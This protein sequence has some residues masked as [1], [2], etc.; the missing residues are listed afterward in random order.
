MN[1]KGYVVKT[2]NGTIYG[3]FDTPE[4]ANE[5]AMNASKQGN[6]RRASV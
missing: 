5:W 6:R 2:N 3:V 1:V 4:Q